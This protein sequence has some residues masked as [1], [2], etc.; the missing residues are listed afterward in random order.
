[1]EQR[2]LQPERMDDPTLDSS[3]H[4]QALRGL[5]RI[6]CFSRSAAMIWNPLRAQ[7][8]LRHCNVSAKRVL[9]VACGGGDVTLELQRLADR[10]DV[11]VRVDGCDI[12]PIAVQ[13][14]AQLADKRGTR[15]TFFKHDALSGS[16]PQGY[17]AVVCSLFLHHLDN[18]QIVDLLNRMAEATN[19]I[20]VSDLERS[21]FG[22]LA[23]KIGTHVL[24]RSSVVHYDGPVSVQ[25]AL[26][27]DEAHRLAF[28]AGLDGVSVDPIFPCRWLLT[29][30]R[31]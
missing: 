24:S 15:S 10:D 8:A 2:Q 4:R 18:D 3:L 13:T 22:Y 28:A 9:D 21:R 30:S 31:P 11:N 20:V 17:D 12:S 16:L 29:W 23:A 14:A 26:T 25:A 7:L 19:V 5:A 6:N 27:V 1:M